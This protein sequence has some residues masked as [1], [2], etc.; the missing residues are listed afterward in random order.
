MVPGEVEVEKL[1]PDTM[2]AIEILPLVHQMVEIP[3]I[4]DKEAQQKNLERELFTLVEEVAEPA[5]GTIAVVRVI[6]FAPET[7]VVLVVVGT[8]ETSWIEPDKFGANQ[9][10]FTR[11]LGGVVLRVPAVAAEV[12]LMEIMYQMAVLAVQVTLS[13]HGKGEQK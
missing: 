8:V 2:V 12:V 1:H 7:L 6:R 5:L 4:Q 10:A 3:F 13:S 9:V 11:N